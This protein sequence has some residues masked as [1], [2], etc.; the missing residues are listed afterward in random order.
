MTKIRLLFLLMLVLPEVNAQQL[1]LGYFPFNN[2]LSVTSNP[3]RLFWAD[4]RFET[5]TFYGNIN[6]ELLGRINVKRTDFYNLYT[7]A[8]FKMILID[9]FNDGIYAGGYSVA[10]GARFKPIVKWSN[11]HVVFEL[12]PYFNREFSSGMLRAYLGIAYKFKGRK[13]QVTNK[14]EL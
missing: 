4:G 7:G 3:D 9:G 14:Q 1:S 10:M 8:G 12:S 6:P 11:V 2:T 5:N 13:K